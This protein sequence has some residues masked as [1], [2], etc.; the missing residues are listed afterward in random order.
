MKAGTATY[1][2]DEGIWPAATAVAGGDTLAVVDALLDRE[3]TAGQATK[4]FGST[5]CVWEQDADPNTPRHSVICSRAERDRALALVVNTHT[6][7]SETHPANLT[8]EIW[9]RLGVN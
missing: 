7:T 3:R 4:T 5:T 8:D 6:P 9:N 2:D 1:Q